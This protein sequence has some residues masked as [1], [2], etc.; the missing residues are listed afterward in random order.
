[1]LNMVA[2]FPMVLI[3]DQAGTGLASCVTLKPT[4]LSGL[5]PVPALAVVVNPIPIVTGIPSIIM[6]DVVLSAPQIVVHTVAYLSRLV[7]LKVLRVIV[8]LP[9]RIAP[10][11][12]V[13]VVQ[14]ITLFGSVVLYSDTLRLK[15]GQHQC[16][17]RFFGVS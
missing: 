15:N 12:I 16:V 4:K 3:T 7:I 6:R 10:T 17:D 9:R 1:M 8:V 5:I 14:H 13:L 2:V 11:L